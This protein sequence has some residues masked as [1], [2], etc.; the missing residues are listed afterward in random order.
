[1]TAAPLMGSL[2]TAASAS[3]ARSSENTVALGFKVDLGCNLQ[4][5]TGISASHVGYTAHLPLAPQQ[6][7]VIKLRNAVEVN[8]V[9]GNHAAFTQ[10]GQRC[11][12]HVSARSESDS[13]IKLYW[14]SFIFAA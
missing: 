14:R 4:K 13:A 1:M 3:L 7:V 11:D 6:V 9:D 5:I 10:A 8:C 12:N 2:F